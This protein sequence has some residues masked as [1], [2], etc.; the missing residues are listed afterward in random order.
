M[1]CPQEGSRYIYIYIFN[2]ILL[3][4]QATSKKG[5]LQWTLEEA[6]K[7]LYHCFGMLFLELVMSLPF[8][9]PLFKN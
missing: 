3:E 8:I 5:G 6:L 9:F 2:L 7:N 1:C 4:K